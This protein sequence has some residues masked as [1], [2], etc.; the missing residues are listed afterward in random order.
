MLDEGANENMAVNRLEVL[1]ELRALGNPSDAQFL[2]RFFKTGPGE[3]GAGDVFLGIRAPVTRKVAAK[4]RDMPLTELK[5]LIRSK[6]HEA[7]LVALIILTLQYPKADEMQ[8]QKIYDFYL[9]NTKYINNWDLV[10]VSAPHV[11][12]AHLFGGSTRALDELA[13]S[14]DLWERRIAIIATQYFLRKNEFAPTL[15]IA[16]K[17][18]KDEHDLIHKA[19]GWMLR[20]VGDR[21]R[22][23]ELEFLRKHHRVMPRTMLRYA[24]EKFP[25]ALRAE[26]AKVQQ[27]GH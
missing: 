4:Y 12:G 1:K 17:L 9:A 14:K 11:V 6:E 7:R 22:D 2:Q 10:D 3:Y 8:Q 16:K 13:S 15:R 18:L 20:E 24:I 19:V 26:F 5:K 25:V 23:A 21:D 27:K